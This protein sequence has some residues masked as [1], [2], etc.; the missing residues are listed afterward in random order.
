MSGILEAKRTLGLENVPDESISEG[1][2]ALA[3]EYQRSVAAANNDEASVNEVCKARS[4]IEN[5]G[6]SRFLVGSTGGQ[7]REV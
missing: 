6:P 7:L 2:L 4:V 5:Y 3:Y 1:V